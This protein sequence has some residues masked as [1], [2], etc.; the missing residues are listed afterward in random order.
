MKKGVIEFDQPEK[1]PVRKFVRPM[2]AKTFGDGRNF[3]NIET[4][5]EE[6]VLQTGVED[7]RV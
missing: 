5:Y 3:K 4:E 7:V 6:L 1:C 2:H